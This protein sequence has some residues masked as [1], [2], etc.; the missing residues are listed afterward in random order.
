M[1]YQKHSRGVTL[2]ELMATLSVAAV[3]LTLGVPSFRGVQL[4]MQR[5]QVSSSLTASFTLA[6]SEAARRA[7]SVTVCPT[8]NGT[9]CRTET[10][11]DW[12]AGW[13]VF[14]DLNGDG[15]I[16]EADELLDAVHFKNPAFSLAPDSALGKRVTFASSGFPGTAG[17]YTYSDDKLTCSL[18]LTA[19]GRVE[20]DSNDPQCG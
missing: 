11:P 3:V 8:M 17:I 7:V 10:T 16:D 15:V 9:S 13:L 6:R 5:V 20:K 4:N 14:T 2:V 19:V 18:R 12:K 1:K